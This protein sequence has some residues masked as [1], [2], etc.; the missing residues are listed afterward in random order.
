MR[1][2]L[3]S[4]FALT[5]MSAGCY[6]PDTVTCPDGILCPK[7]DSCTG[8]TVGN[9]CGDE[10]E[11]TQCA[12]TEHALCLRSTDA[13]EDGQPD[14]GLCVDKLCAPC[15]P[16]LF[17]CRY[18][19]WTAVPSPASELQSVWMVSPQRAYAVGG[20][21]IFEYDGTGWR[22]A[23]TIEG[24]EPLLSVWALG[25]KTFSVGVSK[26]VY[27]DAA[28]VTTSN[29]AQILRGITGTS[30]NDLVVVGS[31]L[32]G[33]FDGT[34]WTWTPLAQFEDLNDVY[35]LSVSDVV[36]AVGSNGR[37]LRRMGGTWQ[38]L[39]PAG[40]DDLQGVWVRGANDIYA[41]GVA[42]PESGVIHHYT[43][44]TSWEAQ[45]LP[46]G[47]GKLG[48]IWG[49][50]D[51]IYAVGDGGAILTLANGVWTGATVPTLRLNDVSGSGA[52]VMA[53]GDGG[54]IWRRSR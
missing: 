23:A 5:A 37:A 42:A 25:E 22:D 13:N 27:L 16:E 32:Y 26:Q 20:T 52:D 47:T 30:A 45:A 53:V 11:V 40:T 31:E 4:T 54:S 44:G 10:S 41:V 18:P 8:N 14:N 39:P 19:S 9:L 38:D 48:A 15:S 24:T 49:N 12:D 50:A 3:A 29:P 46:P 2:Q 6:G 51:A 7:G 43:G 17:E 1:W 33:E 28:S 36:V 35:A 34:M 21:H